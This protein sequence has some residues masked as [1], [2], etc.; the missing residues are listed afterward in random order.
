MKTFGPLLGKQR[1]HEWE[2]PRA[3]KI[4]DRKKRAAGAARRIIDAG[5]PG[6]SESRYLML[7]LALLQPLRDRTIVGPDKEISFTQEG[8]RAIRRRC[9]SARPGSPD[10]RQQDSRFRQFRRRRW[11]R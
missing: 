9:R 5:S 7:E 3:N 6:P 4:R 10:Q 8:R 1:I 11:R 2:S